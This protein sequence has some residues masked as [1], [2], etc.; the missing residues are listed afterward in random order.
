MS[1]TVR[2]MVSTFL[3]LMGTMRPCSGASEAA[4][5]AA[6]PKPRSPDEQVAAVQAALTAGD[7]RQAL[8][9]LN[10]RTLVL[11]AEERSL[12]E[13]RAHLL[14]GAYDEARQQLESV[15][16]AK[17]G[18]TAGLYWLGRVYE[19][20]GAPG[21]AA[22]QYQQAYRNGLAT[23]ELHYH[24]AVALKAAGE[25]LGTVSRCGETGREQKEPPKPGQFACDGV[26][27]GPV[28][29]KPGWVVVSPPESAI[30]QIHEALK[31]EP[32]RGDW[33]L[34]CAEIW[35]AAKRHEEA[36]AMCA[37]AVVKLEKTEDLIRCHEDWA[38]SL[39][40]MGEFDGYLKH[41]TER[42][43]IAGQVDSAELARCWASAAGLVA[44]R[45]D[46]QRQ[47]RYLTMSVELDPDAGRLI[48]LADALTAAQ[49][50]A[51][52]GER[53]KK[54]L[55][56]NPTAEQQQEIHRRLAEAKYLAAP[57]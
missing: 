45:G 53:L 15:V 16:R 34:L 51:E 5:R 49:R 1:A 47:I 38:A 23:A 22:G 56:Q 25:V 35:A 4:D 7:G 39:L 10:Q 18:E 26:V 32:D 36:T 19:A 33:M 44:Q 48:E 31:L 46:L 55:E 30:Y 20:D 8:E 28:A 24:W 37:K 9:L 57:R 41:T 13:G 54:A 40:A 17:P 29:L 6:V 3:L 21:L 42:M 12:L 14:L 43:R 50:V 11:P 2:M 52:A 27:V